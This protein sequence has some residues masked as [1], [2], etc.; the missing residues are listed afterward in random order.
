MVGEGMRG[1]GLL[2]MLADVDE[3]RCVRRAGS[4]VAVGDLYQVGPPGYSTLTRDDI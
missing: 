4:G 3:R 2:M 1:F